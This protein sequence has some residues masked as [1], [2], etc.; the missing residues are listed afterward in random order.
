MLSVITLNHT[1]HMVAFIANSIKEINIVA[2]FVRNKLL[3]LGYVINTY[4]I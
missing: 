3:I 1:I 2:T 4:I